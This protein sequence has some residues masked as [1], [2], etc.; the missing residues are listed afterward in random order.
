[1]PARTLKVHKMRMTNDSY[2]TVL[3][4]INNYLL[5]VNIFFRYSS[6]PL[7]DNNNR[8]ITNQTSI[9]HHQNSTVQKNIYMSKKRVRVQKKIDNDKNKTISETQKE[10][11]K[12]QNENGNL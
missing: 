11:M 9:I 1:M 8:E 4:I 6:N 5:K 7:T 10:A 3:L 12:S 2:Y